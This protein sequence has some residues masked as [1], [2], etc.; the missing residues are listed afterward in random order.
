MKSF[1]ERV[2]SRF[3]VR[4]PLPTSSPVGGGRGGGVERPVLQTMLRNWNSEFLKLLYF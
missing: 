2:A 4:G 3:W 1:H